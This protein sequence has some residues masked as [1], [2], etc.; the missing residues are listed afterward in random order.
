MWF[1]L[2]L[3]ACSAPAPAPA[4]PAPAAEAPAVADA[5]P[6][7]AEKPAGRAPPN[8]PP[9]IDAIALE[10]AVVRLSDS[11]HATVT[12][13]DPEGAPLL[14]DFQ[15]FI[16]DQEV[17][18]VASERLPAGR[19][20]KGDKIRVR[21]TARDPGDES[22]SL[23]S[24]PIEVANSSPVFATGPRDMKKVDGFAF[25]AS[26][27]DGDPL[28]W[29][30]EGA[31][32]GMRISSTGVLAYTGTEDEPGGRYEVSVFVDDGSAWGKYVFPVTVSAGSKAAK[33][34]A[35]KQPGDAQPGEPPAGGK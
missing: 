9:R 18:D 27:P 24:D 10:P 5:A 17:L 13:V 8:H 30:I 14:Y 35:A 31:P 25:T 26:D 12:A 34:L 3:S 22:T 1:C 15:W 11:V 7:T 19:Y 32:P 29:R 28:T 21:A 20:K 6:P 4:T 16:N 2:L 33:A 23:D